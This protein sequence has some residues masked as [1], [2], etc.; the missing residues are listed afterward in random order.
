MPPI[1]INELG[2]KLQELFD[3]SHCAFYPE[4]DDDIFNLENKS[5]EDNS[6]IILQHTF[7]M[8]V[9]LA[10]TLSLSKWVY[11]QFYYIPSQ[12]Y[13]ANMANV[14]ITPTAV[15]WGIT[16]CITFIMFVIAGLYRNPIFYVWGTGII[17]MFMTILFKIAFTESTYRFGS[18]DLGLFA[19]LL[20]FNTYTP[21]LLHLGIRI[22]V[23][24]TIAIVGILFIVDAFN[25]NS[26]ASYITFGIAAAFVYLFPLFLIY[27]SDNIKY[28]WER[29]SL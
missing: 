15:L 24:I 4:N 7:F 2:D 17:I 27:Y 23:W 9:M 26:R 25:T 12:K 16:T 14:N 1:E 21:S 13:D 20:S 29:N 10:I 19:K 8:A 3:S 11:R 22:L 28:I 5:V 6:T 18:P